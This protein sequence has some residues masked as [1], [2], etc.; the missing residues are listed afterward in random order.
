MNEAITTAFLR[1]GW[2]RRPDDLQYVEGVLAALIATTALIV[3]WGL[4]RLVYLRLAAIWERRAGYESPLARRRIRDMVRRFTTAMLIGMALNLNDWS[5]IASVVFG[6]TLAI[7][8]ALFV[9]D[10]VRGVRM[11]DWLGTFL[12]LATLVSIL[13]SMFG[14]LDPITI[15]MDRVGFNLGQK[16]FSLL[17]VVTI[18]VTV[19]VLYTAARVVNRIAGHIIGSSDGLDPTQKLLGQKIAGVVVIVIAF[20]IGIDALGIDLTALSFFSGAFGLAIGFGLQK[21]IGNLFAGI[22]LLLDRSIKPGDVIAVGDSFGWVNKIG[23][24]AVSVITRDGKEHLIPNEDLMTTA[25]ENWSYSDRNVRMRIPVGVAYTSDMQLVQELLYRAV[26]ESPRVLKDPVP[27]IWM[28]DFGD[29]SVN[30]EIR[31][32]ISD[33]EGG[34]G[35]IRGDVLMRVWNLFQEH[36]IEI[37]FPQ[38]DLYI[39]EMPGMGGTPTAV[40]HPGEAG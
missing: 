24:R 12:G 38:R 19:L 39:K 5:L 8:L 6:L 11:P 29:N 23:V 18:A 34:M 14:G 3:G 4:S 35:N 30:W 32:W 20:F 15:A 1:W 25:V 7:S 26:D 33:P 17:W 27:R 28:T 9:N 21:T 2:I 16:R 40:P 13:A 31:A 36:A 10:L 37:P 22:I